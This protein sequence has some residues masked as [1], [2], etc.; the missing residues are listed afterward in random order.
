MTAE[1]IRK[2]YN[3]MKSKNDQ[4]AALKAF[5]AFHVT[6]AL[7]TCS[8]GGLAYSDEYDTQYGETAG[9]NY[10]LTNIV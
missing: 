6:E 5:A 10:P 3:F 2:Q 4:I 1:E 7:K 8:Q 9:G